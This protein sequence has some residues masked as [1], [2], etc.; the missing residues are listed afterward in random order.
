MNDN[1]KMEE[2]ERIADMTYTELCAMDDEQYADSHN[3]DGDEY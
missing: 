3:L 2:W 1:K